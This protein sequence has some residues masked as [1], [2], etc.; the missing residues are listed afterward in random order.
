LLLRQ[1]SFKCKYFERNDFHVLPVM[2]PN[3]CI[4]EVAKGEANK[5][6]ISPDYPKLSDAT[7]LVSNLNY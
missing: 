7:K 2:A 4:S 3:A 1:A 5:M 6:T